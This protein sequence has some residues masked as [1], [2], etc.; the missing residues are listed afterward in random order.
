MEGPFCTCTNQNYS[1]NANTKQ[2]L[3]FV[4]Q[5]YAQLCCSSERGWIILKG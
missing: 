2:K 5:C 3:E 4:A 1:E